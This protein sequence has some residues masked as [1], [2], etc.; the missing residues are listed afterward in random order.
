MILLCYENEHIHVSKKQSILR[1][2]LI[3]VQVVSAFGKYMNVVC[4][5]LRFTTNNTADTSL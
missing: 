5:L 3:T 4:K 2:I 1:Q